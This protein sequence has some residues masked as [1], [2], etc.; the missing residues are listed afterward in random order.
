MG[1]SVGAQW[2]PPVSA[3]HFRSAVRPCLLTSEPDNS[4]DGHSPLADV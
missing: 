4:R 1:G 2:D 3:L